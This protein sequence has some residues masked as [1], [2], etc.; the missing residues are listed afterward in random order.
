MSLSSYLFYDSSVV[1]K[2][3][4]LSDH[5]SA[6]SIKFI[7]TSLSLNTTENNF[8]VKCLLEEL[9]KY[10]EQMPNFDFDISDI[11]IM[12]TTS[13]QVFSLNKKNLLYCVSF[14][15]KACFIKEMKKDPEKYKKLIGIDGKFIR[16][17]LKTIHNIQGEHIFLK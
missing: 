11:C 8:E 15:Q 14:Y 7:C 5:P 16:V 17:A 3:Q 9:L 6:G 12:T 10:I 1:A 2:A 4:A 13:F